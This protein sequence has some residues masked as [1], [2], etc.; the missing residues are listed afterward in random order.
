MLGA[1]PIAQSILEALDTRSSREI[2]EIRLCDLRRER[3]EKMSQLLSRCHL[4]PITVEED[5]ESCVS[6][7]NIV[8]AA[9]TGSKGYIRHEWIQKGSLTIPMSLDDC[10]PDVLLSADKVVV[11]D[12]EQGCREEKLLHRLVQEGKFS[13]EKVYATLGEIVGGMKA[14]RESAEEDIYVN[15]MGMGVEDIAAASAVYSNAIKRGVGLL[16][17]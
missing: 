6:G 17:P 12:F 1:G 16:L 7:A 13:R 2:V 10:E 14:G 3:A 8:I 9:T 15:A 4:P 5:P 11:D